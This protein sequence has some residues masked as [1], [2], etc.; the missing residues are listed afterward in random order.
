MLT[1]MS[2]S[3]IT[4]FQSPRDPDFGNPNATTFKLAA[5]PS[6]IY[7]ALKDDAA[8]FITDASADGGMRT[9]FKPNMQ[10]LEIVRFGL[11]GIQNLCDVDN[12][13]VEFKTQKYRFNGAF[14]DVLHEDVLALLDIDTVRELATE[15]RKLCELDPAQAK[16]SAG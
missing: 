8:R 16:N 7:T 3:K 15:I 10:S 11:K 13:P 12:V 4:E 14:Y 2:L 9:D 6:R 1:A 5:I